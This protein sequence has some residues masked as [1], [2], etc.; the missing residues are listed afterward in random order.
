M[1]NFSF[2]RWVTALPA[3]SSV[4]QASG[5]NFTS[6]QTVYSATT[7]IMS[8]AVTGA[9]TEWDYACSFALTDI[10][11]VGEFQ[12]LFDQ[13]RLCAVM[14]QFKLIAVPEN[15]STPNANTANYGNFY[16]T[17]WFASDMDDS[18]P[19]SLSAIKEYQ[20]VRHK[21]LRSNKEISFLVRCRPLIQQYGTATSTSYALQSRSPWVDIAT[22]ASSQTPH[23]GC[24]WVIDFEG[25]QL[26]LL[27]AGFQV[28]VNAKYYFQCK[29]VR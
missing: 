15:N 8:S 9:I 22:G 5:V 3:Y 26:A 27:N 14:I 13:Y 19:I 25:I 7:G 20:K 23:Y 1:P 17:I 11:N 18:A 10:Q 16:P 21:V 29:N 24:K 4:A 12:S 28:K 2:H 6:T